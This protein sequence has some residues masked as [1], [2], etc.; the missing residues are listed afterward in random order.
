MH[1]YDLLQNRANHRTIASEQLPLLQNFLCTQQEFQVTANMELAKMN[2]HSPDDLTEERI[3]DNFHLLQACDNL[4]LRTCVDYRSPANL[5]HPLPVREGGRQSVNVMYLDQRHFRL[6]PYPFA[7]SPL[8]IDF[9]ARYVQSTH[10]ESNEEL[11]EK[12]NNAAVERLSV[13]L[14][15]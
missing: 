1:T 12:F 5:L 14:E 6:A 8:T 4:S 3:L 10:F 9:P 2:E 11:R 13:T 15:E 7:K